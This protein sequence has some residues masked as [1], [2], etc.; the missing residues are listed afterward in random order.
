MMR[1]GDGMDTLRAALTVIWAIGFALTLWAGAT[2]RFRLEPY[3][4]P[5]TK[6]GLFQAQRRRCFLYPVLVRVRPG[7]VRV[8]AGA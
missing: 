6:S 4:L 5:R 1:K 7:L 8:P 2:D 3:G